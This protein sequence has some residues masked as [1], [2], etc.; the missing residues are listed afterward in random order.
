MDCW[1]VIK[2]CLKGFGNGYS[3]ASDLGD[4]WIGI[5]WLCYSYEFLLFLGGELVCVE[6][7][8]F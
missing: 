5:D 4:E 6:I 7:L 1:D 3:N 2:G 8:N